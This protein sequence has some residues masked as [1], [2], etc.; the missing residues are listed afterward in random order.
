MAMPEIFHRIKELPIPKLKERRYFQN[1][2]V[3]GPIRINSARK[4]T[5]ME[6]TKDRKNMPDEVPRGCLNIS[7][8]V[9]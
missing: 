7:A 2:T 5:C 9:L 1:F 4:Q 6:D 8:S 3:D